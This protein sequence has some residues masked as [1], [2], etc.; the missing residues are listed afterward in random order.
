[1]LGSVVD[2]AESAEPVELVRGIVLDAV[3]VVNVFGPGCAAWFLA[4][5]VGEAHARIA[6]AFHAGSDQGFA[7]DRL[8]S[9][10][11]RACWRQRQ[12]GGAASLIS[13]QPGWQH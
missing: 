8:G 3:E 6:G 2:A 12:P 13:P 11:W 4:D 10:V 5:V 7:A 9:P 1:M